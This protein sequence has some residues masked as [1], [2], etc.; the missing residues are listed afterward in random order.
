MS[1]FFIFG[2]QSPQ[3]SKADLF[4]SYLVVPTVEQVT[5]ERRASKSNNKVIVFV[6][7][8]DDLSSVLKELK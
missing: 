4:F 6:C 8:T 5:A 7:N 2:S 3:H 1:S